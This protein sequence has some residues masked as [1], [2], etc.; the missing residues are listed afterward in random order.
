MSWYPRTSPLK[1]GDQYWISEKTESRQDTFVF[2][3]QHE[4]ALAGSAARQANDSAQ[5]SC[6][7]C[8][9][10][11]S[12][13]CTTCSNI[14]ISCTK[15]GLF[16]FYLA[17]ASLLRGLDSYQPSATGQYLE[18]G[19]FADSCSVLGNIS[20]TSYLAHAIMYYT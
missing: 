15:F 16:V 20:R 12:Q 17:W 14:P 10:A 19:Q 9:R 1:E 11:D 2:T 3:R 5:G 6:A 13:N 7:W 4:A 8:H 18:S